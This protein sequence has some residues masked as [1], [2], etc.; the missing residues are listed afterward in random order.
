MPDQVQVEIQKRPHTPAPGIV[1]CPAPRDIEHG[2]ADLPRARP[3]ARAW[4]VS[5]SLLIGPDRAGR[6]VAVVDGVV[7]PEAPPDT[8]SLPCT[9]GEIAPGAVCAHTHLYSGLA[10]HGMP[11]PALPPEN[12]LQILERVWWRLDRALDAEA[13]PAAARDYVA[14]ALLSGTTALVDHHESPHLID[15]PPRSGSRR[16]RRPWAPGRR[17]RPRRGALW[18]LARAARAGGARRRRGEGRRAGPPRRGRRAVGGAG[19]PA[20]GRRHGGDRGHCAARGVPS[21]GAHG[22]GRAVSLDHKE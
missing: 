17:P 3:R 8:R 11:P 2:D 20:R 15:L 7:V 19:L 12:F 4:T 16:R 22:A 5:A 1:L 6:T 10:R 13:L 14:R 21:L 18:S 9:T